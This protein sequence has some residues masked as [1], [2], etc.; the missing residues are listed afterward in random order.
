MKIKRMQVVLRA[1]REN[2]KNHR[3]I[4]DETAR[5][6]NARGHNLSNSMGVEV[7]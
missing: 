4:V 2:D 7:R 1:K 3:Q 5:D 6:N